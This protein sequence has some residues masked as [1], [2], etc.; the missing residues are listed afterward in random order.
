MVYFGLP[1]DRYEFSI[2]SKLIEIERTL[3]ILGVTL[4]KSLSYKSH[5]TNMLKKRVH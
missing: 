2:D 3:K 5:I 1:S 4:D